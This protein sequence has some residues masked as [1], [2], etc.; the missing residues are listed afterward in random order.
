MITTRGACD[1]LTV[2]E[3]LAYEPSNTNG[4]VTLSLIL[5]MQSDK[6]L[7]T[8]AISLQQR[9]RRCA[10]KEGFRTVSAPD[11]EPGLYLYPPDT[12]H[13]S[14]IDYYQERQEFK[15]IEAQ[16]LAQHSWRH[17]DASD[18]L[19][20]TCDAQWFYAFPSKPTTSFS[21]QLFI[22]THVRIDLVGRFPPENEKSIKLRPTSRN[23]LCRGAINLARFTRAES[24]EEGPGI[25]EA[26]IELFRE[27]QSDFGDAGIG[28]A[29]V[30]RLC[31]VKSNSWLSNSGPVQ[32]SFSPSCGA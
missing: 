27:F 15:T 22:P 12:L 14:L 8:G 9:I 11:G 4:Y 30:D 20:F 5:E 10:R 18:L 1:F 13:C 25:P 19:P 17:S 23:D 21:I 6:R 2:P 7:L 3:E 26:F 29:Y 16:S 31:V 32:R 28:P 24:S